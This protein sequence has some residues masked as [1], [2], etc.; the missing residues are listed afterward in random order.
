MTVELL[1][2]LLIICLPVVAIAALLWA[3]RPTSPTLLEDHYSNI[4]RGLE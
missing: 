3:T 2:L 4:D 1:V